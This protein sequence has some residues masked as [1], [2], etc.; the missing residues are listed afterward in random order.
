MASPDKKEAAPAAPATGGFVFGG[1]P[2]A[3][4]APGGGFGAAGT[5]AAFSAPPTFTAFGAPKEEEEGGDDDGDDGAAEAEAECTATFK[6]LVQLEEVAT[7]T[8]EEDEDILFEAKAKAYRF[9]GGEWKEKGMGPLKLLAHKENKKVR[10]LMRRDK[11]LKVC[12]NFIGACLCDAGGPQR[13]G[14]EA[15]CACRAL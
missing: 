15:P 10:V 12:V 6:P 13:A 11:T 4:V 8:G 1:T 5:G 3:A 2:F 9:A 14:S 7:T